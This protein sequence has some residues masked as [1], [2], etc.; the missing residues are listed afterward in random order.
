[1]CVCGGGGLARYLINNLYLVCLYT[2]LNKIH[3]LT[4]D[5]A[6]T[7]SI[8]DARAFLSGTLRTVCFVNRK[9]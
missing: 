4:R 1:M 2:R 3:M 5:F 6:L 9:S 7:M 8:A